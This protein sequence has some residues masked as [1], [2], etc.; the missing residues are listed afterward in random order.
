MSFVSFNQSGNMQAITAS[1]PER[2]AQLIRLIK[3]PIKVVGFTGVPGLHTC[4]FQSHHKIV[5][6]DKQVEQA[7]RLRDE[8]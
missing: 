8:H 7:E 4:Y 6:K 3:V 2:L 1:T 5:V